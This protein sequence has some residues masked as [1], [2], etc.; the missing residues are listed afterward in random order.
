MNKKHKLLLTFII[1]LA[2]TAVIIPLSGCGGN[3]S[4][5]SE[6]YVLSAET[7]RLS[8]V[9]GQDL[10]LSTGMLTAVVDGNT[11]KIPLNAPEV[12][13]TGYN[14]DTVGEQVL[15]IEYFG[16]TT[17]ITV[18]VIERAFPEK[19]ET[20]YFVGDVFNAEKGRLKITTDDAKTI[21]VNMND[22]KVSLVSFDSTK[23]GTSTVTLLYNDGNN[24]YNCKF[25]VTVYEK[26]NVEFTPPTKT[27][28]L[29]HEE[30]VDVTN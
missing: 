1:A 23:P 25:D 30:A 11:T 7:P 14:K 8:Y 24:S 4:K 19:Y 20:K 17:T 15:T 27:Q 16:H 13:V 26:S 10:D 9:A 12:S 3:S 6:I 18:T 29:S 28:Y 22:A 5:I 2:I 21:Y